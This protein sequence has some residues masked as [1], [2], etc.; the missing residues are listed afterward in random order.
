MNTVEGRLA[1]Y[2][3]ELEAVQDTPTVDE[4]GPAGASRPDLRRALTLVAT[5]ALPAVPA[6]GRERGCGHVV[7]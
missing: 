1:R 4:V 5:A 2:R 7:A 3:Y 6:A